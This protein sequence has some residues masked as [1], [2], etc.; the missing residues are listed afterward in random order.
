MGFPLDKDELYQEGVQVSRVRVEPIELSMRVPAGARL[1][2]NLRTKRISLEVYL[3]D[4]LFFDCDLS[5]SQDARWKEWAESLFEGLEVSMLQC[6]KESE[7]QEERDD[8]GME[9]DGE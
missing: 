6:P 4:V 1:Y 7:A 2:K 9:K 3:G 5:G 8:V